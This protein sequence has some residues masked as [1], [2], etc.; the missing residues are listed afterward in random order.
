MPQSQTQNFIPL[1]RRLDR[2]RVVL[3]LGE[4][5][6]RIVEAIEAG[7]NGTGEVN[8]KVK[9][10]SEVEGTY[11][12]DP[13][14]TVKIPKPKRLKSTTFFN[15][16]TG[17]LDDRDPRQPD[18][19]SVVAADFQNGVRRPGDDQIATSFGT[20]KGLLPNDSDRDEHAN[21]AW[22][23]TDIEVVMPPVP[24][25]GKQGWG[26]VS[27]ELLSTAEVAA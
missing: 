14:V 23:L 9:V 11:I 10:K 21:F 3:D 7:A 13:E 15:E 8:L 6:A 4:G 16:E 22:P 19:P 5:L 18:L 12:L 20:P 2:G 17:G 27:T 1:L 25:R 26:E 24:F